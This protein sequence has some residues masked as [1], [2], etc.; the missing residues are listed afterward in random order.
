MFTESE[1]WSQG[2]EVKVY[3]GMVACARDS[4]ANKPWKLQLHRAAVTPHCG[5]A[6]HASRNPS[7]NPPNFLTSSFSPGLRAVPLHPYVV[8]NTTNALQHGGNARMIGETT[9]DDA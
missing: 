4:Y 3:V 6:A 2:L 7:A 9:G 5:V 8:M 1:R